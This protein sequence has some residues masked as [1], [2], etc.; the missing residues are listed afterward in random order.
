MPLTS[1]RQLI[2]ENGWGE[3]EKE[4][5]INLE[6]RIDRHATAVG[7]NFLA[8]NE[9]TACEQGLSAEE[10]EAKIEERVMRMFPPL[11]GTERVTRAEEVE[12]D[13]VEPV[14]QE[15]GE[16]SPARSDAAPVSNSVMV[17][18]TASVEVPVPQRPSSPVRQEK[19]KEQEQE[20]EQRQESPTLN[21]ST[22][23]NPPSPPLPAQ[24]NPLASL[25]AERAA[26][27]E[28]QH[29]KRRLEEREACRAKAK[30]REEAIAADP[31]KAEQRKYA[32]EMKEQLLKEKEAKEVVLRRIEADKIARRE[33]AEEVKLRRE[34]VGLREESLGKRSDGTENEEQIDRVWETDE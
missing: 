33:R 19:K 15:A 14:M 7:Y 21:N 17:S 23:S 2:H 13:G 26:R 5:G 9:I 12:S 8:R 20:Q 29:Q 4:G 28:A 18:A 27:L 32:E 3:E 22:V 24:S 6:F 34:H 11:W 16:A 1:I 31:T 10:R 30:A 25:F